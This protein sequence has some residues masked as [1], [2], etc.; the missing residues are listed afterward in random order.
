MKSQ[1]KRVLKSKRIKTKRNKKN[2]L[3]IK[4]SRKKNGGGLKKRRTRKRHQKGGSGFSVLPGITPGKGRTQTASPNFEV[5]GKGANTHKKLAGLLTRPP[6]RL[7]PRPSGIK[8]CMDIDIFASVDNTVNFLLNIYLLPGG[9]GSL[10]HNKVTR[11]Y[12]SNLL[13]PE[14]K[15]LEGIC[16]SSSPNNTKN[17]F[18]TESFNFR[19]FA[20]YVLKNITPE[21]SQKYFTFKKYLLYMDFLA[22]K[23]KIK[24]VTGGIDKTSFLEGEPKIFDDSL[25]DDSLCDK[26][27]QLVKDEAPQSVKDKAPLPSPSSVL[28]CILNQNYQKG[29]DN[30]PFMI[31]FSLLQSLVLFSPFYKN[32]RILCCYNW[33]MGKNRWYLNRLQEHVKN[34]GEAYLFLPPFLRKDDILSNKSFRITMIEIG[35]LRENGF[36]MEELTGDNTALIDPLIKN[37]ESPFNYPE[38]MRIYKIKCGGAKPCI[39][40]IDE[41]AKHL[42]MSQSKSLGHYTVIPPI[43]G[44]LSSSQPFGQS[45]LKPT[46][47]NLF[48][49]P[50]FTPFT[51][52]SD[53]ERG[54]QALSWLIEN[55]LYAHDHEIIESEDELTE[56]LEIKLHG[57]EGEDAYNPALDETM[58]LK[59]TA[60]ETPQTPLETRNQNIID[61]QLS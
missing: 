18:E 29:T 4:N 42:H 41:Y 20:S 25:L 23:S 45:T 27:L 14:P 9:T 17:V 3:K 10:E 54:C 49:T 57:T 40:P 11:I 24:L 59:L 56:K 46:L 53:R 7:G 47:C 33:T 44:A 13:P 36:K 43:R 38:L 5:V 21:L 58:P 28:F 39:D 37:G 60:T 2:K 6:E 31:G 8:E 32:L 51:D 19:V 12:I 48:V 22:R 26:A 50:E 55:R 1:K 15:P 35:T 16:P 30:K 34:N 61:Y 52:D